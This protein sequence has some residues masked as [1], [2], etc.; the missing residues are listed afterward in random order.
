MIDVIG[1]CFNLPKEVIIP[2]PLD[3]YTKVDS[4]HLVST[5][6]D[7][8]GGK[9]QI[10]NINLIV[11]N[12]P[13]NLR[14]ELIGYLWDCKQNLLFGQN[15]DEHIIIAEKLW[16]LKRLRFPKVRSQRVPNYIVGRLYTAGGWYEEHLD[17]IN[18]VI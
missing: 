17:E 18:R 9:L 16:H 14:W 13:I 12:E 6:D 15:I 4:F 11:S 2:L 10:D 1:T 7:L 8:V 5:L 3:K